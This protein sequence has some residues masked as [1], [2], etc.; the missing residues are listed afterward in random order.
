MNVS[1]ALVLVLS[2][3]ATVF[4]IYQCIDR[5][6]TELAQRDAIIGMLRSENSQLIQELASRCGD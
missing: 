4:G 2:A 1:A 5:R 3:A 6:D